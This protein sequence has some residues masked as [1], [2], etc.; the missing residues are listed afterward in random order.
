MVLS[1]QTY[2]PACSKY[3]GAPLQAAKSINHLGFVISYNGKYRNLIN[4]RVMKA[5][6]VSNMVLQALSTN[7]NV[8]VRLALSLF[9][10]Q[11]TPILLYGCPFFLVITGFIESYIF[12][13][14]TWGGQ[15]QRYCLES[16]IWK[17][18]QASVFRIC[19]ACRQEEIRY[20][21]TYSYSSEKLLWQRWFVKFRG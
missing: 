19:P 10:K 7:K 8:S 16:Y 15:H 14:S 11:I 13:K 9:D 3:G 1:K 20:K 17:T 2:T 18:W 6:M 5:N 21:Q 12:D 4:D